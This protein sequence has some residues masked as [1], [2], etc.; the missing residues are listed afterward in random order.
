METFSKNTIDWTVVD[1]YISEDSISGLALALCECSKM[2]SYLLNAQGYKGKNIY[3]KIAQARDRF[4]DLAGLASALELK[5]KII[6]EYDFHPDKKILQ[7]AIQKCR[8]AIND[9]VETEILQMGSWDKAKSTINYY[10]VFQKEFFK[11][12][13]IWFFVISIFIILVDLTNPGKIIVNIFSQIIFKVFSWTLILG[14]FGVIFLVI[15]Y[16][17]IKFFLKRSRK[18]KKQ[19]EESSFNI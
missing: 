7:D 13:L 4:S 11:R 15:I 8:K 19:K 14:F 3:E 9:L 5:E 6:D 1:E 18:K 12:F 10:T 2:I 16:L 17:I